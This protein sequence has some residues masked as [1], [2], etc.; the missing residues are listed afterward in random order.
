M[1]WKCLILLVILLESCPESGPD[2]ESEGTPT[3]IFFNEV[4]ITQHHL[5]SLTS[6][7]I[8]SELKGGIT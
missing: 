5:V 6:Q 8:K 7:T 2:A 4:Q 1:L 3:E